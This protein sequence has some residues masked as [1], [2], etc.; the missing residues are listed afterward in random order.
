MRAAGLRT[1]SIGGLRWRRCALSTRHYQ[2]GLAVPVVLVLVALVRV[3]VVARLAVVL[4]LVALVRVV[5]VARA[6]VM[7]VLVAF[8]LVVRHWK[9]P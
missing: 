1:Y 5:D 7:L 9:P 6:T 4:V 3:V 2:T 8:V